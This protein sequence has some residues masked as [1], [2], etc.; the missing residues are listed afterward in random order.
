MYS[1]NLDKVFKLFNWKIKRLDGQEYETIE[2]K[3]YACPTCLD[4]HGLESLHYNDA[5]NSLTIEDVPPKALGGKKSLLTCKRCNSTFGH[6]LDGNLHKTQNLE[7]LKSGEN[8]SLE[9]Y[10]ELGKKKFKTELRYSP[11]EKKF[12]FISKPNPAFLEEIESIK[13]WEGEKFHVTVRGGIPEYVMLALVRIAYLKLF[14]S[15][16]YSYSLSD[17][18]K[19]VMNQINSGRWKKSETMIF[20]RKDLQDKPGL[21]AVKC[22]GEWIGFAVIFSLKMDSIESYMVSAYQGH[23]G[24]M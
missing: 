6:M 15:F 19:F 12:H 5:M 18:G 10:L 8:V 4:L 13:V 7:K 11:V 3:F 17:G 16:G 9:A 1:K 23:S 24:L 20:R 21:H 22:K 2:G 14:E